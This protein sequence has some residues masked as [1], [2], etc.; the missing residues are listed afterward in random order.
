LQA[1]FKT[2]FEGARPAAVHDEFRFWENAEHDEFRDEFN[3]CPAAEFITEFAWAAARALQ[4]AEFKGEF[5]R[6]CNRDPFGA[7]RPGS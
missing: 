2:E 3:A 1:E 7:L 6:A 5:A 4:A